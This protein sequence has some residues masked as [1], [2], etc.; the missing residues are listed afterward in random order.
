MRGKWRNPCS[1]LISTRLLLLN[2]TFN[3]YPRNEKLLFGFLGFN[4]Y[5]SLNPHWSLS[6]PPRRNVW[7]SK[8]SRRLTSCL[9]NFWRL[10]FWSKTDVNQVV[11]G[12]N[13]DSNSSRVLTS[14]L[15]N[16]WRTNFDDEYP[17]PR[18]CAMPTRNTILGEFQV[19]VYYFR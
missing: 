6:A 3:L 19:T 18:S 10:N 4:A 16:P 2:G 5:P 9:E 7:S 12:L 14:Q 11:E 1:I 8:L 17:P 13:T 15:R